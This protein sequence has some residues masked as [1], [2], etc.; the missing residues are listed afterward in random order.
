MK[1]SRASKE[2]IKRLF[3]IENSLFKDDIFALKLSSFYYHIKSS[4]IYKVKIGETVGYIL[5]LKRKNFFRL[6]SLAILDK[7]QGLGLAS[8]LIEYS[9]K[10]LEKKPLQLEVRISN[11]KAIMLYKKFGF[12]EVK[13]LKEYYKDEDGVL[14]RLER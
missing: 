11:K 6:Y 14:M 5:W 10:N 9:L 4:I 2:D 3:E 13:I 12:K 1:I 7:Y 8:S